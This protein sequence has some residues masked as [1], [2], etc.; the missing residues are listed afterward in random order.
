M[1][2]IIHPS[3]LLGWLWRLFEMKIGGGG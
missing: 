2:K 1:M 3:S